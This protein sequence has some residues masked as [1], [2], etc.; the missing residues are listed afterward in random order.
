MSSLGQ[1]LTQA[2]LK[3]MIDEVDVDGNGTIDFQEFLTLMARKMKESDTE[4]ELI[5]TFKVFDRDG[6]GFISSEELKHV[7]Q[8][9]G[10]NFTD[11]LIDDLLKEVI[12]SFDGEI[13]SFFFI[14]YFCYQADIDRDG[15]VSYEDFVRMMMAK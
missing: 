15:H 7:M 6:D 13:F 8:N 4:Y 11:A 10:N 9:L 3:E 2:E 5:E 14:V 12:S 1:N